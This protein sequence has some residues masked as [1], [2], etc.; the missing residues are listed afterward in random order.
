MTDTEN[1]RDSRNSPM[2]THPSETEVAQLLQD[3]AE[4]YEE[5]M[6]LADLAE[7]ADQGELSHPRYGW[8][9]PIGLVVTRRSNAELV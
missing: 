6:R 8:D 1:V 2:R 3:A 5:C 4:Q 7:I 9:N